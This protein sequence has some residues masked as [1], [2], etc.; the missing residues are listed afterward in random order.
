[1][2][3]KKSRFVC[4]C[5]LR[6]M[7][8]V[9][10]WAAMLAS[11]AMA[12]SGTRALASVEDL[13]NQLRRD[14]GLALKVKQAVI[15]RAEAEGRI[16]DPAELTD[17]ALYRMLANDPTVA[18]IASEKIVE[19]RFIAQSKVRQGQAEARQDGSE[20]DIV[21]PL[22]SDISR[23]VSD[24]VSNRLDPNRRED[25]HGIRAGAEPMATVAPEQGTPAQASYVRESTP[26]LNNGEPDRRPTTDVPLFTSRPNP[27]GKNPMLADM[28]SQVSPDKPLLQ[29][30]GAS[31]FRTSTGNGS[32]LPMDMPVGPDYV[33][34]P[35]DGLKIELWGG[36]AEALERVIDREGK[37][38][39]PEVG[40]VQVAGLTMGEAQ[41]VIQSAL[42][43][44]FRDVQAALSLSRLRTVRI[45]V[46]GD[47]ERPGAY[48][49]SSLST[50]LNALYAAGG[51]TAR[52]SLRTLRHF[53]GKQLIQEVDLYELI[54][55]GVRS[56]LQRL[57]NGD[58]V[59]VP[60]V[61][62]QVTIEGLVH[63]PGIYE[64][65][66]EKS[67]ADALA[68]AGGVL[69]SGAIRHLEL[70]RVEAHE[71]RTMASLDLGETNDPQQIANAM[72]G[73]AIQDGDKVRVSPI[74]P[75][76]YKSVYLDG[77]VF[78]PGKYPWREGM[79]VADLVRSYS[80]LLPEPYRQYAEIIRLRQP[81]FRPEVIG[82]SLSDALDG[83][84][85]IALEPFDTV[86]I[87]G[88]YDFEDAPA[89]QVSG[90][91]RTPG[92][93]HMNGETH[94]RDAIFL[95][96]GPTPDTSLEDVHIFRRVEG[97][98]VRVLS[99]NLGKALAGDERANL[100]L[101]PRDQ[102]LVHRN[103]ARIDPPVVY[104]SGQVAVPGKYP[105]GDGLTAS[106][107]VRLAGG[108]RRGAYTE[109]ADLSRFSTENGKDGVR[110]ENRQVRID[111]ALAGEASEDVELHD[112]DVLSIRQ[113]AGWDD[114]GASV[115]VRGEVAHAGSYGIT[116]G[117]RLSS[118]IKRAGGFQPSAYPAGA[119]LTRTQ[120]RELAE[121][122]K[123]EL[124]QRLQAAV[125][126]APQ[127]APGSSADDQVAL[128]NSMRQQQQQ[129]IATLK[130]QEVNGRLIIH[131][132]SDMRK[133][134]GT[135]DDI[136]LR[137]GDVLTVPKR[138]TFVLVSGQVYS[139]A[140]ITYRPG[141]NAAWYL[142]R[143]GGTTELAND[144]A[145]FVIRADG[146]VVGDGSGGWWRGGVSGLDLQPGD[147]VV[148]PE[149]MVSANSVWRSLFGS[150]Q[151]LSA[152]AITAKMISGL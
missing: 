65:R 80:D 10:V 68:L 21:T 20:A 32:D 40:T 90:E 12:A 103:S 27:Y 132:S 98:K 67:L 58:T 140:A 7:A 112:G 8:L 122:G 107:L 39:L 48:D 100:L 56:G 49:I 141:K 19:A 89:I 131:I 16:V 23:T 97:S 81:E 28:Y 110:T 13:R 31:I 109:L 1:M 66:G 64:L 87:F 106:E 120:V 117:E 36:I 73:F 127:F 69:P 130:N 102:V 43:A 137:D 83:R 96:G 144:K 63:R 29:R 34:G 105:L 14:P 70:E 114:I 76:S 142:Q 151:I 72:Q 51:P 134:E 74:L 38:A 139:P 71:R 82:F 129:I 84:T 2:G 37:V 124:L 150:A 88:R 143:A 5:V 145:M 104:I 15:D 77:H 135:A 116:P 121:K 108:F 95:A 62:S 55:R 53:R 111:Q 35:G 33:I 26:V 18:A 6:P 54:L 52:G 86:R 138:P 44:Q 99:A 41:S 136:E 113:K 61:G 128:A 47:V 126:Q 148:V 22:E 152:L 79:R 146:S 91:V 4:L 11:M 94:L 133:W 75:Y 93:H 147:T 45:Y 78:K 9:V 50:P 24:P 46:V 60:P 118:L 125:A 17:D 101:Q 149:K 115:A 30:F 92:A 85:N 57:E 25:V 42:R 123:A 119:V 59:L 3:K